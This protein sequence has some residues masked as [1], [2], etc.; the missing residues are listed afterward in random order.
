MADAPTLSPESCRNVSTLART[1]AAARSRALC[2]PDHAA[3]HGSL[4]DV[5]H[6]LPT[7]TRAS[8]YPHVVMQMLQVQGDRVLAEQT[9]GR[10]NDMIGAFDDARVAQLLATTGSIESP[11]LVNTCEP[12]GRGDSAWSVVQAVDP[13]AVGLDPLTCL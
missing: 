10:V 6:A 9:S 5:A 11:L 13:D 2:P 3:V 4:E 1:L 7:D 12:D 8:L